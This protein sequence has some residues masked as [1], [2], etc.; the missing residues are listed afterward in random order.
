MMG[1]KV[2]NK[3]ARLTNR[4]Y[5]HY[6]GTD[7]TMPIRMKIVPS[8]AFF[9]VASFIACK[10]KPVT[11]NPQPST[12]KLSYGDSVFYLKSTTYVISPVNAKAGSYSP[13]PNNLNIN[14]TTGAITVS[15]K[16]NDGQSQTGLRYKIKFTSTNNEL[17]STFITIAGITYLDRFYTLSKNDSIIYPIYNAD[18]SKELPAGNFSGD[19][20]LAINTSNGQINVKET[21][22]RGFFDNQLNASWKQTTIRYASNDNSNNANNSIDVILYYYNSAADVPSNVSALM[23]AHQRMTVGINGPSVTSTTGAIDNNLS[24]DLSLTKPR[25]PCIVIVGQ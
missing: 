10:K 18:I 19:N 13:F 14:S 16:G 3:P 6:I 2:T 21:I 15:L 23:Q 9:L 5:L 7:N 24:S 17:D 1:N 22:R 25:P 12:S 8:L 4:L 11:D 20:K